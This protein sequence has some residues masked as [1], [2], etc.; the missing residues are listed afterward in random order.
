MVGVESSIRRMKTSRFELQN[1]ISSIK[2]G[3]IFLSKIQFYSF[4]SGGKY[5]LNRFCEILT[6]YMIEI[7]VVS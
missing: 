5:D 6:Y 7:V 4:A 2:V 3:F 1:T